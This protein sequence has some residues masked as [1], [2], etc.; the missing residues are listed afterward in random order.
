VYCY[1][2]A[3]SNCQSTGNVVAQTTTVAAGSAPTPG[4]PG[5]APV[6]PALKQALPN[7]VRLVLQFAGGDLHGSLTRDVLVQP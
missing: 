5:S 1:W 3:W 2:G 7:G 4:T 6:P